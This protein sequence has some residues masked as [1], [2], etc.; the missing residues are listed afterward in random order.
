MDR[1]LAER[2]WDYMI[3]ALDKSALPLLSQWKD[4]R[5]LPF[6]LV[7]RAW[8]RVVHSSTVAHLAAVQRCP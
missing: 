2:R 6:D 1:S 7:G 5:N 3:R 8:M 4:P